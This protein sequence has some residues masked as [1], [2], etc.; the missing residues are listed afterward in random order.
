MTT[1]RSRVF[2]GFLMVLCLAAQG[3]PTGEIPRP[4]RTLGRVQTRIETVSI[5]RDVVT[6]PHPR[7][8]T[9]VTGTRPQSSPSGTIRVR[10]TGYCSCVKCCGKSNGITASGAVAAWGTIAAPKGYTF[11]S[12]FTIPEL[13]GTFTVQDRGG[14]IQGNRIDIWFPTHE[15]AIDWGVRT[16]TLVPVQ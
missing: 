11:G 3:T 10:A 8:A 9:A 5:T 12:T 6:T 2:L 15:Q 16:V 13:G 1:F 7:S 4:Y 14:A